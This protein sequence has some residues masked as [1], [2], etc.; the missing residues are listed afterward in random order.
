MKKFLPLLLLFAGMAKAQI[1]T[2]PNAD[3]KAKLLSANP[4]NTVAKN[5]VGDYISIDANSNGEIELSEALAVYGLDVSN[6]DYFPLD[7]FIT[8][9]TGIESFTNLTSLKCVNHALTA[10]N[11]SGLAGLQTLDCHLNQIPSLAVNGLTALQYLDCHTNQLSSLSVNNLTALQYF[12]CA[13]NNLSTL[14]VSNLTNLTHFSCRA[15]HLTS[16]NILPLTNLTFLYLANNDLTAIDLSTLTN[17]NFLDCSNNQIPSLALGN[18]VNLQTL[19]C[20]NNL[21]TSLDVSALS[22]LISLL[23]DNNA[24]TSI[25]IASNLNLQ[26]FVAENNPITTVDFSGHTPLSWIVLGNTGMSSIDVT[27]LPNLQ[28]LD[29]GD[30]PISVLDLT[31]APLLWGVFADNTLLTTLDVSHSP[32]CYI[33]NCYNNPLQTSLFMKN[34][35]NT[36]PTNNF[37]FE[38]DPNLTFI[39]ADEGELAFIQDRITAYGLTNCYTNSYCSFTPGGN[40]NTITGTV[41]FDANGNGCDSND[42]QQ[43]NIKLAIN[44]GSNSGATFSNTTGNYSFYTPAGSFDIAPEV[45][46]P[47]FFNFSPANATVVFPDSNNNISNQSFCVSANGIHPDVEIVVAPLTH[48]RPGF[49]ARYKVV[50]KNKGNQTVSGNATLAY[51]GAL[52][53]FLSASQMPDMQSAGLLT[54]NF[55]N[56]L[57]FENRSYTITLNVNEPTDSPP[58]NLGDVLTFTADINPAGGD[59]NPSDNHFVLGQV[60]TNA[61]DPNEITCLEG[62]VVSPTEIG[63]YLHYVVNFENTGSAE[64]ENIV[65]RLDIDPEK[66]DIN[67]LQMLNASHANYTRVSN[68]WVEFIFESVDLAQAT[69]NPPVGGH[70]NVLFKIKTLHTL[71]SGAQVENKANIYFDYNAPI[72]TNAAR[73]TFQMLSNPDFNTDQSVVMFPNPAKNHISIHCDSIIKTVELFD[74]QG[75][76]L[77][78]AIVNSDA[79]MLDISDK[80]SGIYFVRITTEKGMKTEKLVKE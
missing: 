4:S 56:L 76:M 11:V 22:Q 50:Y 80:S 67:S 9:L 46:N 53:D 20:S 58:V 1:V 48:A 65:V 26:T 39:C 61:I 10:L 23:F 38:N 68:H 21:L 52:L 62:D 41:L 57:P 13:E 19:Y 34:G 8:D 27:M 43:P 29:C 36:L 69:G 33:I 74:I 78:T 47:G 31:N 66:Y 45:E 2:I 63:N 64:A 30:N 24:L 3:F 15:N 51:D 17:L 12:D 44:D 32:G 79:M 75:R 42:I 5:L 6:D 70:G 37:S 71:A 40:Y 25:D 14:D 35:V 59:E 72:E 49:D 73:T 77:Q 54:W 7:P 60:V 55:T 18:L 16:I 28:F